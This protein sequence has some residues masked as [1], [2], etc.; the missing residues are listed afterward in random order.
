M[1]RLQ[2][3]GIITILGVLIL[4]AVCVKGLGVLGYSGVP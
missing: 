2:V 1:H 4:T 3:I